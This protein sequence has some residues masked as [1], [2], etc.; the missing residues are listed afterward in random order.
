MHA[1]RSPKHCKMGN[2]VSALDLVWDSSKGVVW[3]SS[4]GHARADWRKIIRHQGDVELALREI[5][6][7]ANWRH[8]HRH[9]LNDCELS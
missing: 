5:A 4:K 9:R 1:G 3:D 7:N 6:L 2:E 8:D